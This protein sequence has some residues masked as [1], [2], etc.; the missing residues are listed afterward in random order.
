MTLDLLVL[1]PELVGE[2]NLVNKVI[3]GHKTVKEIKSICECMECD[4]CNR[5]KMSEAAFESAFKKVCG[6]SWQTILDGFATYDL[7]LPYYR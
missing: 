2:I 3:Q 6:Y 5:Y 4:I 1:E 7:S